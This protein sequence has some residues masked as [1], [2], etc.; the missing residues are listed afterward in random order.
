MPAQRKYNV[1][2]HARADRLCQERLEPG[3]ISQTRARQEIGE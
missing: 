2:T 3:N 1:E